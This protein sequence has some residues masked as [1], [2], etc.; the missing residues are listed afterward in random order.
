MKYDEGFSWLFLAG[1]GNS[2][3]THWQRHWNTEHPDSLWLEHRDWDN[4]DCEEW[5]AD[6]QALLSGQQRPVV[7]V[8]HSLG[9]L[10]LLEWAV[11]HRSDLMR[12]AFLVAVPDPNGK[13]FPEQARGFRPADQLSVDFPVTVITSQNDPYGD[14][15]YVQRSARQLGCG[16]TNL[17]E[18][19][20]INGKSQ[21]GYWDQ[22]YNLL[23]SFARSLSH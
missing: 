11:R 2:G 10:L 5:V 14:L 20:H 19:G 1:V 3:D 22:G 4:P 12:G 23:Q 16:C 15:D 8:A 17:G 13:Q 9:C 18:L 7:V 21:L 6:L